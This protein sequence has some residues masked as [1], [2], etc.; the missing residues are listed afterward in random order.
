MPAMTLDD[1]RNQTRDVIDIDSSDI[2]DTVLNRIIGQ[3]YDTIAYSEKRWGFYETETTFQTVAGTSDYTIATVGANITQGIRE[4]IAIRDDDH[5]MA[6]VGRDEGDRDNPLDVSTSGD[7]WEWSFWNDTV[8]FYPTP[9]TV[10]TIY[11]RC[12]RFPTDFPSN[13]AS[14]AGSETP[15]LPNPFHP[16]LTTYVIAKAYLQ[17]EDPVMANQYM[18]QYAMELDNVARRYADTPA[19]Q[20]MIANSRTSTRYMIGT[21]Q[22]RYASTGGVRW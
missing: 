7:P 17:Q 2:S 21:G 3:G 14:A 5:V 20:P 1:I 13:A 22:L 8:R 9:D 18:N 4:V 10:K 12:V 16:V 15:D 6:Y 19:P 11:V